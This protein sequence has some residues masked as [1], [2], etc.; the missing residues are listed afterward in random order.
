MLKIL[1]T[2][3]NLLESLANQKI[4]GR[5]LF[6]VTEESLMFQVTYVACNLHLK[7]RICLGYCHKN[8]DISFMIYYFAC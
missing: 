4:P 7:L 6:V 2:A 5:A 1:G 3:V 8:N